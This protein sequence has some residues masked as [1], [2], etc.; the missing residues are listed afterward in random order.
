MHTYSTYT[1]HTYTLHMYS[2]SKRQVADVINEEKLCVCF[3]IRWGMAEE[4]YQWAFI[5]FACTQA[6]WPHCQCILIPCRA[7]STQV[8]VVIVICNSLWGKTYWEWGWSGNKTTDK[9]K[10]RVMEAKREE[11]WEIKGSARANTNRNRKT[12]RGTCGGPRV[13]NKKERN[14]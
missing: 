10:K 4:C 14:N 9:W 2:M 7:W 3:F 1:V 12:D 6:N 11:R 5:A 8:A 13:R